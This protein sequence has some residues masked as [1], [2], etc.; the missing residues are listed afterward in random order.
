MQPDELRL[1]TAMARALLLPVLLLTPL[2]CES[3]GTVRAEG[4]EPDVIEQRSRALLLNHIAHSWPKCETGAHWG[5]GSAC[6][7][8]HFFCIMANAFP[9]ATAP[10]AAIA[11]SSATR[12]HGTNLSFANSEIRRLIRDQVPAN[13]AVG[14]PFYSVVP[15]G[16]RLYFRAAP[17]LLEPATRRAL[18][19]LALRWLSYRSFAARGLGSVQSIDGSENHDMLRKASYLLSAQVLVTCGRGGERIPSD[20]KTAAAHLAAWESFF[21]RYFR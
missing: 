5:Q 8:V 17:S 12:A 19:D 10:G 21:V 16:L 1:Q 14:I 13:G 4:P 3:S 20:N 7:E 11:T 9:N 2:E 18:E 15:L 6:W